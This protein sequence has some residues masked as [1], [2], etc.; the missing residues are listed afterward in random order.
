[1]FAIF[2]KSLKA[3]SKHHKIY[4]NCA[5]QTWNKSRM[6]VVTFISIHSI[7]FVWSTFVRR[8]ILHYV[9][10]QNYRDLFF[11]FHYYLTK[12]KFFAGLF[13]GPGVYKWCRSH[14][15]FPTHRSYFLPFTAKKNMWWNYYLATIQL[16]MYMLLM[17]QNVELRFCESICTKYLCTIMLTL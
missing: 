9:R 2:Q 8:S 16:R 4:H 12:A 14:K 11:N 10:T 13:S 6:S 17:L 3:I 5:P 7:P 15:H 1:M